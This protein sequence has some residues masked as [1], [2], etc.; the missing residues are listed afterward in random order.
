MPEVTLTIAPGVVME[1]APNVGILVLG[2]LHVEGRRGQEIVMKPMETKANIEDNVIVKR[3]V[4]EPLLSESVR[5][6]TGRNCTN[7]P[8]S[9]EFG[10]L[11]NN[12]GFLEYFNQ[13]TLQWVPVCDERFTE[14]NA[15]VICRELGFSTFSVFFD[16]GPRVE[17]HPNSLSRIWSW[18]EPL[19]C[20]GK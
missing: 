7:T 11:V 14:R 2:T 1:F 16:Y 5:L 9:Q 8:H 4:R 13:T 17:F 15:Q 3:H 6:C 12:E 10:S 18:P 19:Q 20:V